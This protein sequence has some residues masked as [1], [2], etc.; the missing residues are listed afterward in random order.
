MAGWNFST[1]RL[2]SRRAKT[3]LDSAGVHP[4]DVGAGFGPAGLVFGSR[5]YAVTAIELQA[6]IG[7]MGRRVVE[8]CGLQDTVHYAIGDVMAFVPKMPADTL[9]AVLCLLRVPDKV[10][11]MR[12]LAAMLRA[13]G[14]GLS[15]G[16]LRQGNTFS[17]GSGSAPRR[18]GVL[19]TARGHTATH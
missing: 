3:R 12:K 6:D 8:A 11:V 10:G 14:R 15:R 1:R 2:G 13:G 7:A 9:I 5:H 4:I 19:G 17:T 18:G 16:L